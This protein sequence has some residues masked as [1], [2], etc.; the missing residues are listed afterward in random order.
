MTSLGFQSQADKKKWFLSCFDQ[1]E[2]SLL[3]FAFKILRNQDTAEEIVQDV[4]VKLWDK[5]K[6]E[7]LGHESQWLFTVT[8]N[9]CY[10]HLRKHKRVQLDAGEIVAEIPDSTGSAEE[11]LDHH[12]QQAALLK[13]IEALKPQQREILHLK[14]SEKKSYNEISAITGM[15]TNH[16]AVFVFNIMKKLKDQNKGGRP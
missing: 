3:R 6:S 1:Y 10:D 14:F 13:Q 11:I 15:S 16:I 9:A 5:F 7:D 12:Q 4:F 8:R 2:S